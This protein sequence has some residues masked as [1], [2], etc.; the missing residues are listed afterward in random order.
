MKKKFTGF[1]VCLLMLCMSIFAGC[2]LVET[3]NNKMYNAIVAEIYNKDNKKVAEIT[4]R[5][6]VSA[7]QSYGAQQVQYYGKTKAEAVNI[8]LTQLQNRKIAVLTAEKMF[9]MDKTGKGMTTLE[10]AY[11]Y[12][13]T[14]DAIKTNLDSYYEEIVETSST[15]DSAENDNKKF[16][17]YV[18]N[19]ELKEVDGQFVVSK[20]D[21]K[22]GLLDGFYPTEERDYNDAEDRALIYDNLVK[23]LY[24]QDYKDAYAKYVE[25]L[26]SAEYG[27]KLSK[28]ENE[29]FAREID[30]IY[31]INYE[32]FMVEKYNE[33]F[34]NTSVIS[35]VT[36]EKILNL[37]SSKVRAD[38]TKYVLE[39]SD[40]YKNDMSDN[41]KDVYYYKN[42]DGDIKYFTVANIL[43]QFDDDQQASYNSLSAQLEA[44]N[45]KD[46]Y[47]EI[48][49]EIE[50]L[51]TNIEPVIRQYNEKSGEYEVI[52]NDSNL[53]VDDIIA[54]KIKI[55]LQNA[56]T[57]ESVNVIGDTINDLIYRYNE[58]PG[59]F[60][61]EVP[62]VIGVED[63]KAVSNF[64]EE[65]NNAGLDLYNNGNG[66]VGDVAVA[67]SQYGIHVLIYTG[68]CENLFD[69]INSK[70]NLTTSNDVDAQGR[71]AIEVLNSTRVN[72]MVDKTYF[73]VLYD[74]LVKDNSTYFQSANANFLREDYQFKVFKG[75][76]ASSLKD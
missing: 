24:N 56:Q 23:S 32:N 12:E 60:N 33:S 2:N 14:V 17:G 13:N 69:G 10:K 39:N 73:D 31:N 11:L 41:L 58:D 45:G 53:S 36:T 57:T 7:Y 26:K 49:E 27:L 22:D 55:E 71:Q 76:F 52:D 75:R 37:Y 3:D 43:F 28:K 19:A 67:R 66:K 54:E 38:Y 16:N 6:L 50:S 5:D 21:K 65:F 34:E 1:L 29:I 68:K 30:R 72:P 47:D 4:N 74:E 25:D 42:N 48:A 63:G 40:S 44:N 46:G 35:N 51:Y 15:G 64:V 62:Y 9:D 70:F 59:M 61:A 18:K 8:T 20:I